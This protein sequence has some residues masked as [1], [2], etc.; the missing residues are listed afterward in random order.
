[1]DS[2][3]YLLISRAPAKITSQPLANLL[4]RGMWIVLQEVYRGHDHA[5]SADAALCAPTFSE[6]LLNG[7][8]AGTS[9]DSLYGTYRS[10]RGMQ[11]RYQAAINQEA[12]HDHR[13]RSALAFAA[14]FFGA[15]QLQVVSQHIEQTLY[16]QRFDNSGLAIDGE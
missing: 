16:G 6:S 14:S 3:D 8:Q 2:V 7:M 11:S 9:R 5:R 1:M 15:R 4:A 10:P 12:I 13:T